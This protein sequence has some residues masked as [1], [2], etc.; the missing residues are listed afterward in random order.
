MRYLGD[1]CQ[2]TGTALTLHEKSEIDLINQLSSS[3]VFAFLDERKCPTNRAA[4]NTAFANE[5]PRTTFEFESNWQK[6]FAKTA[7]AAACGIGRLVSL[8]IIETDYLITGRPVP[9]HFWRIDANHDIL[10][11]Q[12]HTLTA[13]GRYSGTCF[14]P[15]IWTPWYINQSINQFIKSKN[16]KRPLTSQ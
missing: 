3:Y 16:T 4:W 5:K 9:R 14:Y 15:C 13:S 6:A 2:W 10:I 1:F 8:I 11:L 12:R 7:S